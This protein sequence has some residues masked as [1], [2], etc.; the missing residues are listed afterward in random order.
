[1]PF[2]AHNLTQHYKKI[3][4]IVMNESI[5][6]VTNCQIPHTPHTYIL[7]ELYQLIKIA[8][9]HCNACCKI[10]WSNIIAR[11]N[12]LSKVISTIYKLL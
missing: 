11:L 9:V 2:K 1:M 10:V 8:E 4:K 12:K 6:Q 7:N 5:N 3:V